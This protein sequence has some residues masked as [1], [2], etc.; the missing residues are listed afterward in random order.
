MPCRDEHPT[1]E[2][3]N[4]RQ[5]QNR[6]RL[7]EITQRWPSYIQ[8][9]QRARFLRL[10]LKNRMRVN[11]WK[12]RQCRALKAELGELIRRFTA[13]HSSVTPQD[14]DT[15]V[16]GEIWKVEWL[17]RR[18]SPHYPNTRA[19]WPP[20]ISYLNLIAWASYE[21]PEQARTRE[22]EQER[23]KNAQANERLVATVQWRDF[24]NR[25]YRV[26]KLLH[27]LQILDAVYADTRSNIP[28]AHVART[29]M[30]RQVSQVDTFYRQLMT[31][32]SPH[33]VYWDKDD[34]WRWNEVQKQQELARRYLVLRTLCARSRIDPFSV[35]MSEWVDATEGTTAGRMFPGA[36]VR[37]AF[38]KHMKEILERNPN[39]SLAEMVESWDVVV[40]EKGEEWVYW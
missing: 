13:D 18:K 25:L 26:Q 12:D 28:A 15:A 19:T 23:R 14:W 32:P 36:R 4:W 38:S 6:L 3:N 37:I 34:I 1:R 35:R 16:G 7:R 17:Y 10:C 33:P 11:K 8:K 31:M 40:A 2:N 39:I 9:V 29:S 24:L 22:R 5:G 30:M 27:H 20:E 21:T